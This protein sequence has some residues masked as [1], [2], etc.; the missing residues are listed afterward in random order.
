MH[1][2][3]REDALT[4]AR[5]RWG[6]TARIELHE[7]APLVEGADGDRVRALLGWADDL[8]GELVAATLSAPAARAGNAG[9]LARMSYRRYRVLKQRKSEQAARQLALYANL[10][11][12]TEKVTLSVAHAAVVKRL[13]QIASL[14]EQADAVI[15]GASTRAALP[16]RCRI[17]LVCTLGSLVSAFMVKGAGDTWG[18]ACQA[19]GLAGSDGLPHDARCRRDT[20]AAD[21]PAEGSAV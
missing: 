5:R 19:A 1:D 8:E 15:P 13:A 10:F 6:K 20:L 18:S 17:G 3:T 11:P 12:T 4:W 7:K 9:V 16:C 2:V 14:R 21:R